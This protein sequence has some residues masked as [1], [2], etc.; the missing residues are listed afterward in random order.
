MCSGNDGGKSRQ[1]Q[2]AFEEV[3][4]FSDLR[5]ILGLIIT[6]KGT[7]RRSRSA[8]SS[9][10]ILIEIL[11]AVFDYGELKRNSDLRC[12]QSHARRV[13]H[14]F[15]HQADQTLYF[16]AVDFAGVSAR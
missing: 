13:P 10:E 2:A 11:F 4:C 16:L 12:G 5:I 6:W 14:G 15:F 1:A 9:R 8:R 7:G 3:H